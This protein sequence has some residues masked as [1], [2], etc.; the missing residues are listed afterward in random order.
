M[1][2]RLSVTFIRTL[3]V[4]FDLVTLGLNRFVWLSN[5]ICTPLSRVMVTVERSV[6]RAQAI[7]PVA[8]LCPVLCDIIS[9]NIAPCACSVAGKK[10][11]YL[12]R[13]SCCELWQFVAETDH[14]TT[15]RP[16]QNIVCRSKTPQCRCTVKKQLSAYVVSRFR[17]FIGHH[18][19]KNARLKNFEEWCKY[20]VTRKNKLIPTVIKTRDTISSVTQRL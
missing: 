16:A 18:Q 19:S 6:Y 7:M 9:F 14:D 11:A 2:T 15:W 1:R 20:T 17:L 8:D 13:R 3:G 4:H 5:R 12:T 10:S